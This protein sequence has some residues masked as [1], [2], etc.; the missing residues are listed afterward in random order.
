[1]ARRFSLL[2][3][4]SICLL[5]SSKTLAL[6]L[7]EITLRS[8]LNEPLEAEIELL[9]VRDLSER[10][11]LVGLADPDAFERLGIDRNFFLTDIQ[12][13]VDLKAPQGATVY[14]TS[15]RPVRE[16]FLNFVIEARWPSGRLLREYTLLLDLPVFSGEESAGVAPVVTE[17]LS[18]SPSSSSSQSSATPRQSSS[19]S[20]SRANPRS[21]YDSGRQQQSGQSSSSSSSPYVRSY[22]GS[23]YEVQAN[24][25]LWEIAL[26]VR[27]DRNVSV[28]Q[29]MLS[30]QRANPGAF[31]NGNINLLKSGQILRIP[32]DEE[33]RGFDQNSA[34]REVA[35]QNADWRGESYVPIDASRSRD[36]Y[37]RDSYDSEGRLS[38]SSPDDSY[39]SV[40]GRVSG[41]SDS[42]SVQAL[43][44]ELSSTQETLD[45]TSRENNELKSKIARLEEQ[46]Q[47]LEGMIE[48][49]SE[50]LREM[51]LAAA[52]NNQQSDEPVLDTPT[53]DL[54]EP[55]LDLSEV[56]S[57]N[58]SLDEEAELGLNEEPVGESALEED[59]LGVEEEITE[60]VAE[61]TPERA[62]PSRVVVSN[63]PKKSIVDYL[64]EYAIYIGLGVIALLAIVFFFI[65]SRSSSDDFDD[66]E[67]FLHSSG[68]DFEPLEED[69]EDDFDAMEA[70]EEEQE[71]LEP[72]LGLDDLE[73]DEEASEPQTEDVVGEADIYIAYG[74][75]E[76]AE[77]MLL[78]ALKHDET[79]HEAR[80]KLLE[81][82]AAQENVSA[83][84]PQYGALR[85]HASDDLIERAARLREGI[86]GAAAF[87]ASP[88]ES[89]DA[90]GDEINLETEINTE[91]GA[92]IEAA[93]EAIESSET[94]LELDLDSDGGLDDDSGE[95]SLDLEDLEQGLA[96]LE[97]E[98]SSTSENDDGS[99]DFDLDGIDLGDDATQI[100]E[101]ASEVE[102]DSEDGLDFDLELADDSPE[103]GEEFSIEASPEDSLVDLDIETVEESSGDDFDFDLGDLESLDGDQD[104]ALE[105][106]APAAD[107]NAS[108]ENDLAALDEEFNLDAAAE[109]ELEEGEL[110]LD[111]E[112]AA[113]A[114]SLAEEDFDLGSLEDLELETSSESTEIESAELEVEDALGDIDFDLGDD[115]ADSEQSADTTDL[116]DF[117]IEDSDST[118]IRSDEL[119]SDE[120]GTDTTEIRDTSSIDEELSTDRE[121][122]NV[123]DLNLETGVDFDL[124]SLDQELEALTSDLDTSDL[125]LEM[126][127]APAE[128]A[129]ELEVEAPIESSEAPEEVEGASVEM[130]EPETEFD[131]D[132]D[133]IDDT[134]LPASE[135]TGLDFELPDIDPDAE[136]DEDLGFL[137]GSDETA[138]K[139]DLAAAYIDM[140][141][142]EG[143]KEI[144]DEILKE[145]TEEQKAEAQ[146]LLAKIS[147]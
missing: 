109:L 125:D 37:E 36:S 64:M 114:P 21:A 51:E 62:D 28:H 53:L 89:D 19:G 60:P 69:S 142:V 128:P 108:L 133:S 80:L 76:Q 33:I 110:D 45:A 99:I 66:D 126:E 41:G 59:A 10:E 92:D 6:G 106:S 147:E 61:A 124:E 13:R 12:Y 111:E 14:L 131:I 58:E 135:N 50:S 15:R 96:D 141:D 115:S 44:S 130:E 30:L 82:Y 140:G 100:E 144:V 107:L 120:L 104:V 56:D 138:T 132:E 49:S 122:G 47:T 87:D 27:P 101:A 98:V 52:E 26:S 119:A 54:E 40:S 88:Y 67:D 117:S 57:A 123:D 8:S 118:E 103:T 3:L 79:H 38:L 5:I 86:A 75:Y 78:K 102:I 46:I 63:P 73:S 1:M 113:D 42:S 72:E 29:T 134:Q 31:I 48:V 145:G 39:E 139:L 97:T 91:L 43:E 11:V 121:E 95:F 71:D 24:D 16:P 116:R 9:E 143:A 34:V 127:S 55:S 136:D 105:E 83:F 70:L 35:Q 94:E 17:T 137:A 7:G 20:S 23:T 25:T 90:V 146:N 68:N 93:A 77:E 2:V 85:Q 129:P 18:Q 4:C 112:S 22:D 84:D 74:K 65:R 81:V 32:D